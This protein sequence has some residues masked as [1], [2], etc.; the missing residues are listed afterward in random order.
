MEADSLTG[1]TVAPTERARF[2]HATGIMGGSVT[3][4]GMF[5]GTEAVAL[6][7]MEL[8]SLAALQSNSVAEWSEL[9]VT[10][11]ELRVEIGEPDV[12]VY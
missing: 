1:K 4:N 3:G 12:G 9:S 5:G 6:R 10:Q 8:M 7:I 11:V 2:K